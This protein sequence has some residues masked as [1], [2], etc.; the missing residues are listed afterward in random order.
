M[1]IE[2][3]SFYRPETLSDRVRSRVEEVR[4]AGEAID[5]LCFVP[6]GEPTLDRN[7]GHEI[8]LLRPLGIDIGVI[9]NAS[10]ISREDVRDDLM[11]ADWVSLKVDAVSEAVW[12][13]IDRPHGKLELAPILDG[14]LSFSGSFRGRLVTETMMVEGLNDGEAVLG[15][16]ARFLEQVQPEIAYLSVPTSASGR[17]RRQSARRGGHHSGLEP[18]FGQAG[19]GGMPDRFRGRCFLFKRGALRKICS[20][21]PQCIPCDWSL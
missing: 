21:S 10:L 9:T 12:R 11:G 13:Q 17:R 16:L 19:D 4:I 8:E 6:D 3:Q 5:Y 2:R 15:D 1:S 7:M 20:A 18:L 14:I